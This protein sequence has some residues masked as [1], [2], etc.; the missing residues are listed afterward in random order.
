[1]KRSCVLFL[2]V[3]L[4]LSAASMGFAAYPEKTIQGYIM[5]GAGG[6][7]DN[8]ARAITPLVEKHLGGSIVLQNKVGAS[9]AL[10]TTLV[11]NSAGDGY[12]LLYGAENP[13]NYRV[14][15]LSPLSFHDL[16]P[17]TVAVE[18][19]A[20]VTVLTEEAREFPG[21][22][23]DDTVDAMTQAVH[24]LLLVPL[25]AGQTLYP[26]DVLGDGVELDWISDLDY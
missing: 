7:T 16:E 6:G 4:M 11:V 3:L 22:A 13:A 9:G 12:S 23:H 26:E 5:W 21:S 25:L 24:R 8:F 17:I 1:M 19:A 10:A 2:S 20:W 14:L 18:G 15:G